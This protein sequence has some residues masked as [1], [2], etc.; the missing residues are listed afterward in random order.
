MTYLI[1]SNV[2][3]EAKNRHYEFDFCPAFWTWLVEGNLT[4]CVFSIDRV[5][6]ELVERDDELANWTLGLDKGFFLSPTKQATDTLKTIGEWAD[7]QGFKPLAINKFMRGVDCYLV[8]QALAGGFE[9]VM[10]EIYSLGRK[11]IKIP[12]ACGAVGV[13]YLTPFDMLRREGARFVLDRVTE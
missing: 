6:R 13:K 8:A 10:H 12:N 11:R 5:K 4:G 7:K 9:I 2:F 1:D 3:I